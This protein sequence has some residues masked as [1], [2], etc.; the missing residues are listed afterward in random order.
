MKSPVPDSWA[1]EAEAD[2][3]FHRNYHYRWCGRVE[4]AWKG[5]LLWRS[6]MI[7]CGGAG[8]ESGWGQMK[9]HSWAPDSGAT[10]RGGYWGCGTLPS[11]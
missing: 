5:D 4:R 9:L 10:G 3:R 1:V 11:L 7:G 6:W 8:D 2:D